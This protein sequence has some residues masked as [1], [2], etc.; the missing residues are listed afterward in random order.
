M[1]TNELVLNTKGTDCGPTSYPLAEDWAGLL[2]VLYLPG[3]EIICAGV[4]TFAVVS[5]LMA[6]GVV[7]MTTASW[8]VGAAATSGVF[9]WACPPGPPLLRAGSSGSVD[10][11]QT[12]VL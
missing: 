11:V 12:M 4:T 3:V 8:V 6:A 1:Q 9:A 10:T 7:A 5:C 2:S